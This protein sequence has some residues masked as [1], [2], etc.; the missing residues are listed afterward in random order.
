MAPNIEKWKSLTAEERADFLRWADN[1]IK[2]LR[3]GGAVS[4]C[5]HG[6]PEEM[7]ASLEAECEVYRRLNLYRREHGFLGL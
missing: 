3:S 5:F 1:E 6:S 7:I 2:R 4:P